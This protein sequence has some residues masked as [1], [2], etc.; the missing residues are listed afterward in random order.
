MTDPL[1]P[2]TTGLSQALGRIPSGLYILTV[3]HGGQGTGMLASWVQQAGFEPPMVTV[4]VRHDRYVADWI[5]ASGRFV[6]NQ[7]PTG[8]KS[9]I[10]HFGRGFSETAPAFEGVPIR[11]EGQGGPILSSALAFLESEVTGEIR[12]GDHRI[13]LAEVVAGGLLH[14]DGEP[15]LHVRANGFHY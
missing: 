5:A 4:A 10:R 15:F 8:S 6:L 2:E 14:P 11:E 12:S 9:L 3:R 7:L 1:R 13:F